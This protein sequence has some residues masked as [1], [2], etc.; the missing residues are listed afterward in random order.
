M[1][2]SITP[3]GE[4]GRNST[5]GVTVGA[6]LIGSVAGGAGAGVVAGSIG[7]LLRRPLRL[8]GG[9]APVLLLGLVAA[10]L[11]M[12]S[13]LFGAKVPGPRRQVNED[14]LRR[15]RGWVYGLGFGLQLGSGVVT[16]VS[17]SAVY[18]LIA[19]AFLSGSPA[20]GAVIGGS[21]GAVRA[22]TV[23]GVAGV[24]RPGRLVA[25]DRTLRGW[26]R[27]ARRL[28]LTAEAGLLAA[29]VAGLLVR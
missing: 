6:L 14:W 28:A 3:L 20:W 23:F 25:V 1:L 27:P 12:D 21:F 16:V 4:R 5:W 9:A 2:G 8:P 18:S 13:G 22:A 11:V 10:G 29:G 19:A 15:Y 17:I 26:D 24:D 7:S